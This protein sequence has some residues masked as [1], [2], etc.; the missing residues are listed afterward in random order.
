MIYGH[1]EED[2]TVLS[3]AP[4]MK[5]KQVDN[6]IANV[7]QRIETTRRAVTSDLKDLKQLELEVTQLQNKIDKLVS[8]IN[9]K[10]SL[11]DSF[12]LEIIPQLDDQFSEV[13]HLLFVT[14]LIHRR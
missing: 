1:R 13:G 9:S 14:K 6:Y 5:G 4:A 10:K 8:S 3:T 7:G 2:S 11:R 12:K